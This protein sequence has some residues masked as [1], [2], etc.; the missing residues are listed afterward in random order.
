[1]LAHKITIKQLRTIIDLTNK[2][3][4]LE[5]G[6][7]IGLGLLSTEAFNKIEKNMVKLLFNK[8][9]LKCVIN[10]WLNPYD[11]I[12]IK[13]CTY[14]NY[15]EENKDFFKENIFT[16]KAYCQIRIDNFKLIM[17][18]K[19][20]IREKYLNLIEIYNLPYNYLRLVFRY[21]YLFKKK[22]I[23]L[24]D[25]L[26]I[27]KNRLE[28]L[29]KVP[30]IFEIFTIYQILRS[31]DSVLISA[32]KNK[33]YKMHWFNP[34]IYS[35]LSVNTALCFT[36]SHYKLFNQGS[37][38]LFG[39]N[40]LGDDICQM[41]LQNSELFYDNLIS[42][43]ELLKHNIN[44]CKKI[45]SKRGRFAIKNKLVNL[46]NSSYIVNKK[47]DYCFY[48]YCKSFFTL[49]YPIQNIIRILN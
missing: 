16:S 29:L 1:M 15:L 35:R 31:H 47:I 49:T 21:R 3:S 6:I 26:K 12:Y 38:T 9:Y 13:H 42:E 32:V 4:N 24:D 40:L 18:Y 43:K 2:Y 20:I 34:E 27:S 25:F 8:Y 48:Y 46:N 5:Y 39:L 17:K 36:C 14:I 30:K 19:E 7:Y 10:K 11:Y 37:I 33:I 28:I 45:F 22:I 23:S 44:S 41:I